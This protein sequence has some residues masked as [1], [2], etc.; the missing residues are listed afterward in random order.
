MSEKGLN[1]SLLI[2]MPQLRDPNFHRS[3]LLMI[4]H[5]TSAS[6]GLVLNRPADLLLSDLFSS[7]Q[8]EWRGDQQGRVSWG[9]PVEPNSGWMLFGDSSSL[10]F[11]DEQVSSVV[12]GVNFGGS[13][14]VFRDIAEAPPELLRFFLGY[15]GWGPGQLEF[16]MAQ[17]AWLSAEADPETIFEVPAEKMWDHVVRGMGIDPGSLVATAG[18]H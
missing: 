7:L 13:M 15:S 16:E 6:F 1:S 3:V 12:D 5:D 14:D 8:F 17:G 4:E 9:G 2:A 10:G 18:V 11:E